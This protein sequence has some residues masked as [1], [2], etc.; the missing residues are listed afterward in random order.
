MDDGEDDEA[1]AAE[2]VEDE[3]PI[4]D[5]SK[6]RMQGHTDAVY[7][8]AI[9]PSNPDLIASASGDDTGALWNRS[10]QERIATLGGHTD[11]VIQVAFSSSGASLVVHCP[12]CVL[13]LSILA[14]LL[15]HPCDVCVCARAGARV[16]VRSRRACGNG[17]H[18]WG[19]QSVEV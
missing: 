18:G 12:L 17:W 8:V 2:N 7:S 10:T 9:H 1:G 3:E 11:T 15:L 19:G 6:G 13:L 4:V 5:G 14:S 16:E